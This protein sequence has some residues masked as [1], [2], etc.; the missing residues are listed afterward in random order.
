MLGKMFKRDLIIENNLKFQDLKN[1]NDVP[2]VFP[3]IVKA[4]IIV[5]IERPLVHYRANNKKIR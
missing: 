1:S 3:S 5:P 4:K 2:F